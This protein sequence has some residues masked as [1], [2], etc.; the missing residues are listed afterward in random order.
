LRVAADF[1]LISRGFR[2]RTGR[3]APL[4]AVPHLS[5]ICISLKFRAVTSRATIKILRRL[6]LQL[7][8]FRCELQASS[9]RISFKNSHDFPAKT[10]RARSISEAE[11]K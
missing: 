2:A 4:D 6:G 3:N 7:A 8:G 11:H 5:F 10:G 9:E 1:R